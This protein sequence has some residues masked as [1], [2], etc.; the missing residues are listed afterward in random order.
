MVE[1]VGSLE[2]LASDVAGSS[3]GLFLK[4]L[5]RGVCCADFL[6]SINFLK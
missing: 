4:K 2:V 5:S 3:L 1:V 6:L